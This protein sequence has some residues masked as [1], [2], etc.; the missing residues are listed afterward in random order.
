MISGSIKVVGLTDISS[1]NNPQYSVFSNTTKKIKMQFKVVFA[2][3]FATLAAAGS[4]RRADTNPNKGITNSAKTDPA[5]TNSANT[6]TNPTTTNQS[7]KIE[8]P[9]PGKD[10]IVPSECGSGHLR[11]CKFHFSKIV[12]VL[13]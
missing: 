13:R 7:T 12:I 8:P 10:T 1:L 3:A 6:N 5:K 2:L 9:V 11:C 4:I